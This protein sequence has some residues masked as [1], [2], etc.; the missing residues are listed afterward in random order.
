M[1]TA[2]TELKSCD[3]I[4]FDDL[5]AAYQRGVEWGRINGYEPREVFKAAYDYADKATSPMNTRA[6]AVGGVRVKPLV[7]IV[8][9]L[10][11][12]VLAHDYFIIHGFK[13]FRLYRMV[14][15]IHGQESLGA[16]DTLE[17][18]KAAAQ[19]HHEAAI[20]SALEPQAVDDAMVERMRAALRP[21]SDAVFNDNGDLTVDL[22]AAT[23]D[24]FVRAYFAYRALQAAKAGE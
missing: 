5:I 18:A 19:A 1:T 15:N 2:P 9:E 20:L 3:L 17:A 4:L 12:A 6:P 13:H 21:F 10:S 14:H 24:D 7:W 22:G 16:F 11:D 8:N 23:H